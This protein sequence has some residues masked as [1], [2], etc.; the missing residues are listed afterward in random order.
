MV[1]RDSVADHQIVETEPEA[2]VAEHFTLIMVDGDDVAAAEPN[3]LVPRSKEAKG[4]RDISGIEA[5]GR[6][7][8]EQR[9][10]SVVWEPVEQRNPEPFLGQLVGRCN[11]PEASAN[12]HNMRHLGHTLI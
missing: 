4:V 9:L 7:L 12:H 10:K 2:V 1:G 5:P 8:I 3:P 11:A 6:N